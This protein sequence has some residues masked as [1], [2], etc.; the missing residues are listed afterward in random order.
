MSK[1]EELSAEQYVKVDEAVNHWLSVGASTTPC[2]REKVQE[3]FTFIY[4]TVLGKAAP[5]FLWYQ[6]PFEACKDLG[7]DLAKELF[8]SPAWFSWSLHRITVAEIIEDTGG[9]DLNL[10]ENFK[11]LMENVGL[12][13]VFEKTVVCT[14]RPI[15]LMLDDNGDQHCET[16]PAV[17]YADGWKHY[18]WHGISI[19]AEWIEDK[20]NMDPSIAL[21]HSNMELRRCAAEILGWEK[22][23]TPLNPKVIDEHSDP[24]IGT[25][26]EVDLPDSVGS[27]FLKVL[28]GTGRHFVYAVPSTVQTAQEA[29]DAIWEVGKDEYAPE[30][31]T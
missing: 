4:E 2:D 19:P 12:S 25:L 31:R 24:M 27:R 17:E 16:G 18:Y 30:A 11:K 26:L 23:I 13:A 10:I 8:V 6:S 5:N 28:C 21:N 29:Q 22:V 15:K 7:S 1:I 20:A 3:A 9:V 14:E